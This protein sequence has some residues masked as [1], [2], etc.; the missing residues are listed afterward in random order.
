MQIPDPAAAI[1]YLNFIGYYRLSGYFRAVTDPADGL[2]QRFRAGISFQDAVDLYVFD[3]KLRVLLTDAHERIEV[4]VKAVISNSSAL[5]RDPFWLTDPANFDRGSHHHIMN[6]IDEGIRTRGAQHLFVSHFANKYS[7]KYPP[8][9]M[10]METISFGVISRIYEK[11]R[12]VLRL[13]VANKFNLQHDILE[14]WLHALTF[15]RNI[16][17]HHCRVW[18]RVFTIRPKIPKE[19]QGIWPSQ[20]VALLYVHCCVVWHIMRII[21]PNSTWADQLRGLVNTRPNQ[22]SLASMGFP[23]DWAAHPF[24][25]AA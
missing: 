21:A 22:I 8:S 10:I 20:W 23:D 24:W 15:G 16:C 14:S 2:H 17:A 7:N 6:E 3:R 18:N 19:Y 1:H 9:W 4:A 13:P 5:A 11:M 12:G 25:D